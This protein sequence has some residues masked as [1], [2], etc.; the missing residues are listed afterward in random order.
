[1]VMEMLEGGHL[2]SKFEE[3][4]AFTSGQVKSIIRSL[5]RGLSH[6]HSHRIM[7]RDLKP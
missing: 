3:N 5:L 4:Y 1:M 6:M 7:H 2:M